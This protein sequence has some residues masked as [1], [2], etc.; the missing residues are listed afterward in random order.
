MVPAG[1]ARTSGLGRFFRASLPK[2]VCPNC[3]EP[4]PAQESGACPHCGRPLR[5][6]AGQKLRPLDLDFEGQLKALDARAFAA[7]WKGAVFAFVAWLLVFVP[8][9]QFLSPILLVFGQLVWV[10]IGIAGPYRRHF[11]TGRKIVTRW[12]SRLVVASIA[13]FHIV[14]L[15]IP[16]ANPLLFAGACALCW[17]YFRWHLKREHEHLPVAWFERILLG[18]AV[19]LLILSVIAVVVLVWVLSSLFPA[20]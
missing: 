12:L 16:G 20:R 17:V 8:L 15:V 7:T 11:G 1:R 10:R 2:V 4:V 13:S 5:D 14:V 9:V 18:L 6:E 3:R 19:L